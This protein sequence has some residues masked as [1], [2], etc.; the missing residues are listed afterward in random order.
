M[1]ENN[2]NGLA[3]TIA[4]MVVVVFFGGWYFFIGQ[5]LSTPTTPTPESSDLNVAT[6]TANN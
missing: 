4:I 6:T 1:E 2:Y 3:I 5:S